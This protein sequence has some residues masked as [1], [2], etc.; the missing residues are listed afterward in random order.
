MSLNSERFPDAAQRET[1]RRRSGIVPHSEF[2]T[3][4]VQQRTTIAREDA[5][6]RANGAALRPGNEKQWRA[7][8][9]RFYFH[10][11][12]VG[13]GRANA[14][15]EGEGS[16]SFSFKFSSALTPTLSPLGRGRRG[17]PRER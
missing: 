2:V 15:S 16:L 4:P 9:T 8:R 5:R 10:L 13:R 11:S 17:A 7:A 14:V 6:E 1:V 12:S 3:V